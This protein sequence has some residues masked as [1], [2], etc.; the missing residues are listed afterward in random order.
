MCPAQ[1]EDSQISRLAYFCTF[2]VAVL[3]AIPLGYCF[4]HSRP[5]FSG[6]LDHIL[7]FPPAFLALLLTPIAWLLF[8]PLPLTAIALTAYG[9]KHESRTLLAV[10]IVLAFAGS[11]AHSYWI[12]ALMGI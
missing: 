7:F 4:T 9:L 2:I 10:A 12:E 3:V 8:L 1:V 6:L 5:T 11:I